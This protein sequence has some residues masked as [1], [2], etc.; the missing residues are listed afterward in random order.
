MKWSNLAGDSNVKPYVNIKNKNKINLQK[1]ITIIIEINNRTIA[2]EKL[3]N[4]D[5]YDNHMMVID[6]VENNFLC[7]E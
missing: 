7:S 1:L 4:W 2:P 3:T 5:E 6:F